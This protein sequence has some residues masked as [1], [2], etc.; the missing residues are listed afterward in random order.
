VCVLISLES[1]LF[2]ER[3]RNKSKEECMG[4]DEEELGEVEGRKTAIGLY[5]MRDLFK[6]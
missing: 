3:E 2:S 4:W 5:F 6:E 1:L